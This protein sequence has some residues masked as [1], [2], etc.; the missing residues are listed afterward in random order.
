M[1]S[2]VYP[3]GNGRD[4]EEGWGEEYEGGLVWVEERMEYV[5]KERMEYVGKE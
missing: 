5:E 4:S 2:C 1:D 3:G